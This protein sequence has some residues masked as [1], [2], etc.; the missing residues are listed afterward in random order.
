MNK[1][2]V[3]ASAMPT[4]M[5]DQLQVNHGKKCLL[6]PMSYPFTPGKMTALLGHNGSGKSTL[7]KILARQNTHYLGQVTWHGKPLSHWPARAFARQVAYLPQHLPLAHGLS[8]RELVSLGRFAWHGTLGRK[9]AADHQAIQQAIASVDLSWAQDQLVERL[10]GGERQRAWLAMCVV[11]GSHCLLLDE[12]TSALDIAHQHEVLQVIRQLSHTQHLTVIMVLHDINVAARFCDQFL[13]LRQ[14]KMIFSGNK[15]QLMD[16]E[17]L[18]RIYAVP[19]GIIQQP[20]T[21]E[22]VCYVQ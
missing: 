18:K 22:P 7:L 6:H 2:L 5:L 3:T 1:N 4:F 20:E 21:G 15:A 11:Q 8:V 9:T 12:P 16:P 13:A 10:S 17:Q 19:M 14:G